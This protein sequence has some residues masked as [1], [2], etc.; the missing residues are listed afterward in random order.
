MSAQDG[1]A[2]SQS[3][4]DDDLLSQGSYDYVEED[5]DEDAGG[6]SPS[7]TRGVNLSASLEVT[8]VLTREEVE[9]GF[10][11]LLR[12]CTE[13]CSIPEPVAIAL[14]LEFRFNYQ[15]VTE[16][17]FS[18]PEALLARL[19]V[20][21]SPCEYSL[22]TLA[23][24][25]MC[26]VCSEDRDQFLS[27]GPAC[28]HEYC[29]EDWMTHMKTK[30]QDNDIFTGLKCMEP[31]CNCMATNEFLGTL[32]GPDSDDMLKYKRF[33]IDSFVS[34]NSSLAFCPNRAC[35]L[36]LQFPQGGHD[37]D[38][39]CNCGTKFCVGCADE[40]HNPCSCR[41]LKNWKL[42]DADDSMTATWIKANTKDC[43]KCNSQIE[44]NGGC[45]HMTC[46]KCKHEF[47]WI[48]GGDWRGHT[49]CNGYSE[50][51]SS[52]SA[53]RAELARYTH[54]WERYQAHVQSL[55]FEEKTL[56]D[57]KRRAEEMMRANKSSGADITSSDY[58]V[59]AARTLTKC[60]RTLKYT[61]VHAFYLSNKLEKELFEH[62]QA[63][64]ET[65]TEQ[66]ARLIELPLHERLDVINQESVAEKRLQNLLDGVRQGMMDVGSGAGSASSGGG[67]LL[68]R[69]AGAL[70]KAPPASAS[71]STSASAGSPQRARGGKS[72]AKTSAATTRASGRQAVVDLTSDAAN[73]GHSED[74]SVMGSQ[75][76]E[77]LD[78]ATAIAR[79]MQLS[80]REQEA[81]ELALALRTSVAESAAAP[82]AAPAAATKLPST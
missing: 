60:R 45:N 67:G 13:T 33:L 15:T 43:S 73:R 26:F 50:S 5:D 48:C 37:L 10:A 52:V 27:M 53:S 82:A 8:Q 47:C 35:Q 22:V 54:Y 19:K 71:A 7:D 64:L 21:S 61:Y 23:E 59:K 78:E 31:G 9:E 70:P 42:K 1:F 39:Q 62:M 4:E 38:V 58:L 69:A 16:R 80:L 65:N 51:S 49:A 55:K 11:R 76:L 72:A 18:D 46:K 3:Q 57:A 29:V 25:R 20:S 12:R 63:V 36:V 77:E 81:Q 32:L 14:L 44:K 17:F 40:G 24:K 34:T 28:K 41:D 30:I 68:E 74:S 2:R 6:M 56:A 75:E 66:L 79:A